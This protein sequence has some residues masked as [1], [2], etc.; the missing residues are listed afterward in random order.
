MNG[1][2]AR[3]TIDMTH[4]DVGFTCKLAFQQQTQYS[5]S[6]CLGKRITLIF[7]RK[8]KEG[9]LSETHNRSLFT[10]QINPNLK[11]IKTIPHGCRP[12]L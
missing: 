4:R 8:Y 7:H 11:I 5:L 1:S 10:S 6:F 12:T 9:L 3:H 2:R